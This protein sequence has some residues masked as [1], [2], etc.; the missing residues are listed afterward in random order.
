MRYLIGLA[1]IKNCYKLILN[2]SKEQV[3]F[4]RKSGFEI[5][6]EIEMRFDI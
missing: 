4:Y 3:E 6:N 1:R 2:C 5:Y